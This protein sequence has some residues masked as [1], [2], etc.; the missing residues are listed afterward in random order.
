[1]WKQS[2]IRGR[3]EREEYEAIKS[4]ERGTSLEF[5][6]LRLYTPNTGGPISIPGGGNYILHVSTESLQTATKIHHSQI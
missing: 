3:E 4:L 2:L 1:M 6:W 5:Q